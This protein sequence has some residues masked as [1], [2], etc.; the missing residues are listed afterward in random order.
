MNLL[1]RLLKTL[2]LY[3]LFPRRM[4][5]LGESVVAFR[6]WPNDLDTNLHMNNGRYLT[7]LDLGRLDLLLRIGAAGPALRRKW[8]PVLAAVQLRFRRPLNLFQRFEIRTRMVTWDHKWVYLE[9]RIL[10]KGKVVTHALL[11]AAFV[12]PHGS[13][14]MSDVVA[15]LGTRVVPPP[16]PLAFQAWLKAEE[17]MADVLRDSRPQGPVRK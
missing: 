7:L 11:K 13:V 1:F 16:L 5:L 12:G 6:V 14:P 3:L 8:Y 15:L 9:Q 4:D 10:R 17:E 2:A